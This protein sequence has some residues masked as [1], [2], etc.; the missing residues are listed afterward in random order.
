MGHRE[1]IENLEELGIDK[2]RE[3]LSQD[4]LTLTSESIRQGLKT[5]IKKQ[6][7]LTLI[8]IGFV[9]LILSSLGSS[10]IPLYDQSSLLFDLSFFCLTSFFAGLLHISAQTLL[11]TGILHF[12]YGNQEERE[13]EVIAFFD[14][15]IEHQKAEVHRK[16]DEILAQ[17]E[18]EN[19]NKEIQKRLSQQRQ[20]EIQIREDISNRRSYAEEM[21]RRERA[22]ILMRQ[23]EEQL[24]RLEEERARFSHQKYKE[25]LLG[26]LQDLSTFVKTHFTESQS[27]TRL[28]GESLKDENGN[29]DFILLRL[30]MLIPKRKEMSVDTLR[31]IVLASRMIDTSPEK[32]MSQHKVNLF[33]NEMVKLSKNPELVSEAFKD[34]SEAQIK[35]MLTNRYSALEFFQLIQEVALSKKKTDP[36]LKF[37]QKILNHKVR[38]LANKNITKLEQVPLPEGYSILVFKNTSDFSKAK[39]DFKNCIVSYFDRPVDTFGLYY[40]NEP[41]ACVCVNKHRMILEIK[42]PFNERVGNNHQ[43]VVEVAL[44]NL[45]F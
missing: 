24:R 7:I 5:Q 1:I 27:L 3:I 22:M 31:A 39:A 17:V 14:A 44:S 2:S 16:L 10:F 15:Q 12:Y 4:Q 26:E 18:E 11:Y 25:D 42:A 13:E 32:F 20:Q 43:R 41:V 28:I 8:A 19:K 34:Y 21:A 29:H 40:R 35:T 6:L 9:C 23:Q 45:P 36:S 37:I 30:L 38:E 33:S